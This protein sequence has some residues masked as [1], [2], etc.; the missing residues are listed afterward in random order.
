MDTARCRLPAQEYAAHRNALVHLKTV[1]GEQEGANVDKASISEA[2]R[3]VCE[4][5]W[6]ADFPEG[7]KSQGAWIASLHQ[8]FHPWLRSYFQ[9]STRLSAPA[10]VSPPGIPSEQYVDTSLLAEQQPAVIAENS[11]DDAKAS[12]EDVISP[13]TAP[14][15]VDTRRPQEPSSGGAERGWL[16]ERGQAFVLGRAPP[17]GNPDD[18][19]IVAAHPAAPPGTTV[20]GVDASPKRPQRKRRAD[21]AASPAR[22][23]GRSPKTLRT[24]KAPDINELFASTVIEE[25]RRNAPPVNLL[26]VMCR[27]HPVQPKVS[28]LCGHFGCGDCWDRWMVL[29]FE[30]PICRRKTR[31]R[32]LITI[33]AWGE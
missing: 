32:N 31:P 18:T 27:E 1:L 20:S 12:A 4:I 14:D 11:A 24:S 25:Q 19:S 33:K 8:C 13:S 21:E 16:L 28:V 30:C 9:E 29:K 7:S 15:D 3:H 10:P 23:S 5:L 6:K 26:C 17:P 22:P 2:V